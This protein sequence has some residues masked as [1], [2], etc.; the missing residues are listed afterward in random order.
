MPQTCTLCNNVGHRKDFCFFQIFCYRHHVQRGGPDQRPKV[1]HTDTEIQQTLQH[2]AE[3][4]GPKPRGGGE[5]RK[6]DMNLR[7]Q[8]FRNTSAARRFR[9]KEFTPALLNATQGP[10]GDTFVKILEDNQ[11]DA[12]YRNVLSWLRNLKLEPNSL[13]ERL[14]LAIP[15]ETFLWSAVKT[16]NLQ[17]F[18]THFTA[19]RCNLMYDRKSLLAL[20]LEYASDAANV[21]F[22]TIL[23]SDQLN[24]NTGVEII[25]AIRQ[26]K[27]WALQLFIEQGFQVNTSFFGQTPLGESCTIDNSSYFNALI[28]ID[29]LDVNFK[30]PGG[31]SALYYAIQ[32]RSDNSV[33]INRLLEKG[34]TLSSDMLEVALRANR[35]PIAE[36]ILNEFDIDFEDGAILI[37]CITDF[38]S[39]WAIQALVTAGAPVNV[40][41][42][43]TTPLKLSI[44]SLVLNPEIFD[45]LLTVNGIDV[46]YTG[47]GHRP[48]DYALGAQRPRKWY[49]FDQLVQKGAQ[50][51]MEARHLDLLIRDYPL[52]SVADPQRL[53]RRSLDN[54]TANNTSINDVNHHW[55]DGADVPLKTPLGL[56]CSMG[57]TEVVH[58]LLHTPG[59]DVNKAYGRN[60]DTPLL[61]AIREKHQECVEKLLEVNDILV[62]KA[63]HY[64]NTPLMVASM[65]VA[66]PS[67]HVVR[68][69][70]N[71]PKLNCYLR[72]K[73]GLTA[74][75]LARNKI[76]IS[77]AIQARV[78]EDEQNADV[79]QL[80]Q[81][82]D[83][84][85]NVNPLLAEI[86]H[87]VRNHECP[88]C[89]NVLGSGTVILACGHR[90]HQNCI[91]QSWRN[92]Q[93][94]CPLCRTPCNL[95][96]RG[97]E[98][99]Q[100]APNNLKRFFIPIHSKFTFKCIH[101]LK[102]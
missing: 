77:T 22:Q 23:G 88:I 62:N 51:K 99:A 16:Q 46:N 53:L 63:N 85:D 74:S 79:L 34:A 59:I 64:G 52:P 90:F 65:L 80:K 94:R 43:R 54:M 96:L 50:F 25:T 10:Q 100:G 58:E 57:K 11:N 70:L 87:A 24:K 81:K 72:N 33:M 28:D 38:P 19:E 98:A 66:Q 5:R 14:D 2:L 89:F 7:L 102:Q 86:L 35:R 20:A 60:K 71:K 37:K 47:G 13:I 15:P 18:Q 12:T 61:E 36:R 39:L 82:I 27:S 101:Q 92:G 8:P 6:L 97:P 76:L 26:R 31:H 40:S 1:R 45:F 9:N 3:W 42:N 68:L 78:A 83:N 93:R 44:R 4:R 49:H 17:L 95:M 56:A 67:I 84:I 30:S 69:L 41:K 55:I 48:A 29:Q 32:K 75:D 21:I 91:L 73:E